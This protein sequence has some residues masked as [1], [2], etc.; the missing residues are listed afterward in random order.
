VSEPHLVSYGSNPTQFGE[1]YFPQRADHTGTVVV[2][3][4][5]FWRARYDLDYGR[6]ISADLAAHGFA[7]WNIEYRRV[8][9]GGGWPTTADD[10]ATAIDHLAELDVDTSA[11]VAIGHSAGGQ[12]AVLAAGRTNPRVPLAAVVSQ[13]GVLDLVAAHREQLGAGAVAA[14]LGGTP[15]DV[16]DYYRAADPLA[17]APLAVPIL[18]VHARADDDVPITQ[19]EAYVARGGQAMLHE[20]TGDHFA[21]IDP[22]HASWQLVRAALPRLLDGRLPD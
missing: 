12:L 16:P 17:A 13:A 4:G 18:C 20:V 9:N 21:V 2:I 15:E 14:F 3:H 10:V 6:A 22:T 11:V 8:G 7:V 1:L 19:S 5:G